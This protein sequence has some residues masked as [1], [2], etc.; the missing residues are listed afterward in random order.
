MKGGIVLAGHGR[1]EAAKLLKL[2]QIPVIALE[3]L[4][5]AQKRAFMLADNKIASNSA[6][7]RKRLAAEIADLSELL[8]VEKL[9]ISV[10]GFEPAEIDRLE[11]DAFSLARSQSF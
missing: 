10:T 2:H 4:S 11:H 7:D 8:K 3:G 9:D 1:L 6:F 5:S